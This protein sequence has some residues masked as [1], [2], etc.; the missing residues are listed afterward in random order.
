ML[1][2]SSSWKKPLYAPR[3]AIRNSTAAAR[4]RAA[5]LQRFIYD[6]SRYHGS[7]IVS[8]YPVRPIDFTGLKTVPLAARGSKV[9]AADFA[10]SHTKGAPL[11][12]W[13]DSLPRL[14]AADSLRS[15]V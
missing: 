11:A 6:F 4:N 8:R 12:R 3:L 5:P 15:V 9:R 13:L 7:S 14:L 10:A 2:S 1:S